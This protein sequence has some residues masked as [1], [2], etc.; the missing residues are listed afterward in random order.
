MRRRAFLGSVARLGVA[1]AAR[2]Q[3]YPARPIRLIIPFAPEGAADMSGRLL[4]ER[5]GGS[6]PMQVENMPGQ[7]GVA[8]SEYVARQPPDGYTLLWATN[9]TMITGPIFSRMPYDPLASFT[10]IT[11]VAFMKT[12]LVVNPALQARDFGE[13]LALLKASPGRYRYAHAG[14]GSHSQLTG[15]IGRAHG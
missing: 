10:P 5:L 7:G 9:A 15:Q 3:T 12:V 2:A 14:A 6:L 1:A 4:V 13:L 8:A 11:L